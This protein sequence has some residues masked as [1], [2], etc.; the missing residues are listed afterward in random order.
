MLDGRSIDDSRVLAGGVLRRS[1]HTKRYTQR[2][3]RKRHD[4]DKPLQTETVLSD[5][6]QVGA[7]R[8]GT[9]TGNDRTADDALERLR[10]MVKTS[11]DATLSFHHLKGQSYLEP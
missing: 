11:L 7:S 9:T 6:D 3:W 8:M 1:Q 4:T 10:L 2:P 5:D